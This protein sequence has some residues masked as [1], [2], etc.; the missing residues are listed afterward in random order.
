M[1]ESRSCLCILVVQAISAH[2]TITHELLQSCGA[3]AL[4]PVQALYCDSLLQDPCSIVLFG[5]YSE[6]A[7][8]VRAQL[9][10]GSMLV[11]ASPEGLPQQPAAAA[12]ESQEHH[13]LKQLQQMLGDMQHQSGEE[14]QQPQRQ[15]H[16]DPQAA[17][18]GV[19]AIKGPSPQ[20]I[21]STL[22]KSP[23]RRRHKRRLIS[24]S[25]APPDMADAPEEPGQTPLVQKMNYSRNLQAELRGQ[26]RKQLGDFLQSCNCMLVDLRQWLS[27]GLLTA[28]RQ[29]AA[30]LVQRSRYE[31][32]LQT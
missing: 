1:A 4:A 5:D 22:G 26:Q 19:A 13:V 27:A 6:V 32:T 9:G 23:L 25:T 29:D 28:L 14:P 21:S 20:L 16:E 10:S 24:A 30:L 2:Q 11:K 7:A 8:A 18:P 3:A 17:C 15:A 12:P 31:G